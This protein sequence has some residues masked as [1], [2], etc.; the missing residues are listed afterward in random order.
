M[1]SPDGPDGPVRLLIV[2]DH[3]LLAGT[4]AVVLRQRGLEVHTANGPTPDAVVRA[5]RELEP[6]LVL[7]DLDLG[8]GMGCGLDLVHPLSEVGTR[9]VMMTG[10]QDRAR[11]GACVEAGAVGI[12]SK[13]AAF[14]ELV[15]TV[16][17]AAH[18]ETVM[19]EPERT[20]LLDAVAAQRRA[21]AGRVGRFATL[22]P[23]E[24]SVLA[25]LVAGESPEAI[26]RRS[27]VSLATVR[28][29]IRSILLKLGVRSQLAAVAMARAAG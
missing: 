10:I 13:T 15:D 14:D 2:D 4:L 19:A 24:R 1:P 25:G 6:A 17:R 9:V 16:E 5:A 27:Y 20:A 28:S 8:P 26:A 23:R 11:L 7:L 22:S 29:H 21:D 18:G 3:E 12:V